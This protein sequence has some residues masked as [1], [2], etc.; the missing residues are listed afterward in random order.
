MESKLK[1]ILDGLKETHEVTV[2]Q[3]FSEVRV[4]PSCKF[5]YMCGG[6]GQKHFFGKTFLKIIKPFTKLV[7]YIN[8][9]NCSYIAY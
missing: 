5:F 8:K 3:C 9:D 4:P 1:Q 2:V 6:I 7:V